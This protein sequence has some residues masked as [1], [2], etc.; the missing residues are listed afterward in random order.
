[1]PKRQ[2]RASWVKGGKC[3]YAKT[4]SSIQIFLHPLFCPENETNRKSAK[5]Y[6]LTENACRFKYLFLEVFFF[7]AV[8]EKI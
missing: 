2:Y 6:L 3:I 8:G 5:K 1:V 7:L 4:V